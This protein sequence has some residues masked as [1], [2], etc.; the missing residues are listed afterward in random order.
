LH[1]KKEDTG[2]PVFW[3]WEMKILE[4]EKEFVEQEIDKI[5]DSLGLEIPTTNAKPGE[6]NEVLF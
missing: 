4:Q 2:A 3:E 5:R 1:E 6:E